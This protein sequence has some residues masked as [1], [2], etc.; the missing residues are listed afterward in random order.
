MA[1]PNPINGQSVSERILWPR[2][3]PEHEKF[4]RERLHIFIAVIAVVHL[5][6]AVFVLVLLAPDMEFVIPSGLFDLATP[7]AILVFLAVML[8]EYG[9]ENT[10]LND[11]IILTSDGIT[12]RS[13]RL[14][15]L[16]RLRGLNWTMSFARFIEALSFRG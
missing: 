4:R 8:L 16:C 7:F 13:S 3:A 10:S 12:Y 11:R 1:S 5:A 15:W 6:L 14:A 9:V 2:N